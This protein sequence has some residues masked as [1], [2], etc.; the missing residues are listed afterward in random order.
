MSHKRKS[1]RRVDRH[2]RFEEETIMGAKIT[3]HDNGKRE[4][5]PMSVGDKNTSRK[6]IIAS[7]LAVFWA[8]VVLVWMW[9]R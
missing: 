1:M 6:I 3:I 5:A 2:K 8:I 7:A 9:A 4:I